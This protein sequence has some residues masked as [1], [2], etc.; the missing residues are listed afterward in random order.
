[1]KNVFRWLLFGAFVGLLVGWLLAQDQQRREAQ[2]QAAAFSN[3]PEV[4]AIQ[5]ERER[6]LQVDR[7]VDDAEA[8]DNDA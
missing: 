8:S 6:M 3:D 1:M 5:K 2:A 7:W 4:L